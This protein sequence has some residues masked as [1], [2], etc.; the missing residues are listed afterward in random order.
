[1]GLLETILFIPP[2]YDETLSVKQLTYIGKGTTPNFTYKEIP[3]P[4]KPNMLMIRVLTAS[5][6]AVDLQ[7]MNTPIS[8]TAAQPKGI[9]RDFCGV[10]EDVGKDLKEKWRVGDKVCGMFIHVNGQGTVADHVYINPDVDRIIKVPPNLS[11]EEAA[12][13]PLVLGTAM[14]SLAHAKLDKN[15]WVCILGGATSVGQ[16]AIQLAKNYYNVEKVVV[17]CSAASSEL[18]KKLGA[19][20]TIDYRA[21]ANIGDSLMYVLG[22]KSVESN[23][24]TYTN[25]PGEDTAPP[26]G[27]RFQLIFDCAGGTDVVFK[28]YQLLTPTKDG[29]AYV[30]IVGDSKTS[31]DKAGGPTSYFYNTAMVGRKFMSSTGMSGVNYIVEWV[32]PGD[33]LDK[34][35]DLM[36]ER[37]VTV[38]IDSVYD[39]ND[40]KSAIKKL[41]SHKNKGK[42][43]L[44]VSI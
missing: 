35:Y 42:I 41:E 22:Q 20:I 11:D 26:G 15:S 1:M 25:Q 21:A 29:S 5:L 36:L 23:D 39:W 17:T 34:A 40:W 13:F 27:K 32:A 7:L 33:W 44:K 38:K 24:F 12:A 9:G 28:A 31:S 2:V 3:L 37:T 16:C 10:I 30:T 4:I 43:V 19:D 6:N 18:C 8:M 14:R